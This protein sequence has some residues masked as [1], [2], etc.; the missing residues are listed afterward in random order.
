MQTLSKESYRNIQYVIQGQNYANIYARLVLEL[1]KTDSDLF[2]K[3]LDRG[4]RAEWVADDDRTYLPYASASPEE[5]ELIAICLEEK[6]QTVQKK[7]QNLTYSSD[8][9]TIPSTEQIFFCRDNM[10]NVSVK[11]TQWGFK[12]P[13]DKGD[14]DVISVLIA[15]ERTLVQCQVNV[16]VR[17]SDGLPAA[18]ESFNHKLFGT[19]IPVPFKTNEEGRFYL[20]NLIVGKPFAISDS[21]GNEKEFMVDRS[22]ELYEVE[23]PL[24]TNYDITVNNQEGTPCANFNISVNG[25]PMTTDE[26]GKLHFEDILLTPQL[27]VEVAHE[28]TSHKEIYTLARDP[29]KNHFK[30]VYSEKFFSSLDVVVR[31]EDGEGLPHFRLKVG[32]DEHETDEYGHLHLEGIEAGTN[33]RVADAID[34]N[35][36]VDVELQRGENSAEIVLERPEEKQMRIRIVDKN[37]NPV[38]NQVVKL[39]CKSGDYE[40]TTDVDG[41]LFF[42]ATYF[43]NGEK[44]KITCPVIGRRMKLKMLKNK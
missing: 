31:Y 18:Q 17:F 33:L 29:E 16:I 35:H 43:A 26:Q 10:G 2:A 3:I 13:K 15:K 1:P 21:R 42:P 19:V 22:I 20:G 5:K 4:D 38:P 27:T 24:Y 30:F 44:V 40:G 7:L 34:S 28:E 23:F 12:L 6:K 11:L 36:Y 37:G 9:L 41:N 14:I 32:M 8:L 39:N 25:Q